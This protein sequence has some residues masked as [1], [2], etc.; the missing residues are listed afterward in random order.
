MSNFH[1]HTNSTRT[2]G[3]PHHGVQR[4]IPDIAIARRWKEEVINRPTCQA[5]DQSATEFRRVHF[6][7]LTLS[8][9]AEQ[10]AKPGIIILPI[11][12]QCILTRAGQCGLLVRPSV[13][14]NLLGFPTISTAKL[15][16]EHRYIIA[17][18]N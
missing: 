8:N 16:H 18:A 11:F 10:N 12:N 5:T 15:P 9:Y 14:K 7:V 1:F 3:F 6:G 13:L 2:R 4:G 17:A